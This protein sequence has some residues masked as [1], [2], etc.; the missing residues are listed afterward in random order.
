MFVSPTEPEALRAIG[1]VSLLPEEYGADIMWNSK[2]GLVGVQRKEFPSDFLASVQD[3]RLN[4]QL[5]QMKALDVAILMLEGRQNWTT[6]GQLIRSSYGRRDSWDRNQ[7]RNY[8]MSV[9]LRGVSIQ[10]TDSLP[11]TI[12][13]INALRRWSNKAKHGALDNRPAAPGP[14]WGTTSNEDFVKYLYKSLPGI[15]AVLA[16]ALFEHLGMIF[17][18]DVSEDDL[19]SVPGIG[20][21]RASKIIRVFE[22][23]TC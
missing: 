22:R 7:H 12:F 21:G 11:D 20:K 2:L 9:Q 16:D 19:K 4:M 1:A 6:E 18:L 10:T 15:N 8:L 17:R 14:Q 5:A 3:G 13:C 23:G